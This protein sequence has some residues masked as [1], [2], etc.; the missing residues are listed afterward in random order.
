MPMGKRKQ[1][2]DRLKLGSRKGEQF[3]GEGR[4]KSGRAIRRARRYRCA[5]G[6][7]EKSVFTFHAEFQCRWLRNEGTKRVSCRC[8]PQSDY[9]SACK[10]AIPLPFPPPPFSH[11]HS[12][13]CD[14]HSFFPCSAVRPTQRLCVDGYTCIPRGRRGF[15]SS[16]HC[17]LRFC[18]K[19]RQKG[20][21]ACTCGS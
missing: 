13:S 19:S 10:C 1:C 2:G 15:F 16:F 12:F 6:E 11:S 9:G 18:G 21:K 4:S 8:A 17:G 20:A 3:S 7:R 14:C 5:A